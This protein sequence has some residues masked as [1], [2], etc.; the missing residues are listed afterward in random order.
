[1][2]GVLPIVQTAK[3][4]GIRLCIL[5]AENLEEGAVV[6]GIKVVGVRSLNE[7]IMYMTAGSLTVE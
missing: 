6:E 4:Q 2:R 1:M 5:P 7:L 3:A